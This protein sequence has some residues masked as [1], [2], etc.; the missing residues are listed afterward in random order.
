M[1]E[2][3]R[4][5]GVVGYGTAPRSEMHGDRHYWVDRVGSEIR[6]RCKTGGLAKGDADGR[7]LRA[8]REIGSL[9]VR[10]EALEEAITKHEKNPEVLAQLK[11]DR[12]ESQKKMDAAMAELVD[13]N[14]VPEP[15]VTEKRVPV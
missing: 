14:S 10:L 5:L 11:I 8:E 1:I 12:D 7:R 6:V 9:T 13:A 2:R 4:I 3:A 15:T